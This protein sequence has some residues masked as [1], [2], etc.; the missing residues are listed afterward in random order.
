MTEPAF[1]YRHLSIDE[2]LQLVEDIWDSIAE[3]ANV[4]ADAL[5]LSAAQVAEL[6]RRIADADA[7]P[8][9]G[10]PWE[11]VRA[12]LMQRGGCRRAS[13]FDRRRAPNFLRRATGTSRNASVSVLNLR[14]PSTPPSHEL[15]CIRSGI[16]KYGLASGAR[17]SSTFHMACSTAYSHTQSRSSRSSIIDGTRRCGRHGLRYNDALQVQAQVSMGSAHDHAR[18]WSRISPY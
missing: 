5:P 7:H 17:C 12:E 15:E 13:Y 11:Q 6:Q 10:I 3:E 14:R 18:D 1:D 2:R 8:D 4:R 16:R 9:D